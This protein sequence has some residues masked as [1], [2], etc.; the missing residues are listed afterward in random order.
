MKRMM[1]MRKMTMLR[2][3]VAAWYRQVGEVCCCGVI[4]Y[5]WACST[6][7]RAWREVEVLGY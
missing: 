4:W 1:M 6:S 2:G 7:S 3:I 5:G